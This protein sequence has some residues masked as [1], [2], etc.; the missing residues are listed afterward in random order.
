L[1]FIPATTKVHPVF[2][3]H[4]HRLRTTLLTSLITNVD[5]FG[6]CSVEKD[7]AKNEKLVLVFD[8]VQIR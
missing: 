6:W 5:H 3:E 2:V 7:G 4:V 8:H 1:G